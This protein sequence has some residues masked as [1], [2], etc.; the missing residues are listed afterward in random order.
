[1]KIGTL[2]WRAHAPSPGQNEPSLNRKSHIVNRKWLCLLGL[3]L[4]SL[5][6]AAQ[7]NFASLPYQPG[8]STPDLGVSLVRVMGA[9]ALVIGIFLGG[10]WLLRNWQRLTVQRGRA[11]KLNVLE[12]RSL[13]GRQ[14]VYVVGYQQERFLL[15]SSPAGVQFL[16]HL[17]AASDE[18]ADADARPA[19]PF[20]QALAQV[21]GGKAK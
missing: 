6:A 10:V 11:P 19:I 4:A 21:L 3:F 18:P 5:P 1:M 8:L 14:S 9:L 13:G 7:T 16:T 2:P 20:S 15:G 17:P 12:V